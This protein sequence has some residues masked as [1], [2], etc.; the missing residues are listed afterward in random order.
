MVHL[1][2]PVKNCLHNVYRYFKSH[3]LN[4]LFQQ[5]FVSL[6]NELKLN[7]VGI[8][9]HAEISLTSKYIFPAAHAPVASLKSNGVS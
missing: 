4:K 2:V 3:F 1:K 5:V 7:E 8:E 9:R 6:I